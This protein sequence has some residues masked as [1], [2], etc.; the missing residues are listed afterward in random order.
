MVAH[1]GDRSESWKVVM[2]VVKRV[3]W[4]VVQ[5]VVMMAVWMGF[6]SVERKVESLAQ[7]R[8]V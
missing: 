2:L 1:L 8:V 7:K 4:K 3:D 5:R 6:W